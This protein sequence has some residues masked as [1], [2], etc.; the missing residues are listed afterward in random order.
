MELEKEKLQQEY[1]ALAE[2][3]EAL[4]YD[5]AKLINK[6]YLKKRGNIMNDEETIEEFRKVFSEMP[7]L[8]KCK[9]ES[10]IAREDYAGLYNYCRHLI[11]EK[12]NLKEELEENKKDL[13]GTTQLMQEVQK[14]NKKVQEINEKLCK[15]LK[16]ANRD[17]FIAVVL[18][19]IC[20]IALVFTM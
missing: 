2:A 5:W 1:E 14:D 11:I 18:L 6:M 7:D 8:I 13:E 10:E 19:F 17:F 20:I 3:H 12:T 9:S 4:A 15:N 16:A